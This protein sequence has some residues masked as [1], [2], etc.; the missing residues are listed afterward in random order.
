MNNILGLLCV[1][2]SPGWK[3][4]RN[5]R[6]A[7]RI[8]FL[9]VFSEGVQVS[10]LTS[11]SLQEKKIPPVFRSDK[12]SA[13]PSLT[14][15]R[16]R[17]W[18][19][20]EYPV[21]G[22]CSIVIPSSTQNLELWGKTK[23]L[24]LPSPPPV[25]PSAP[26]LPAAFLHSHFSYPPQLSSIFLL[27]FPFLILFLPLTSSQIA[28]PLSSSSCRLL[29]WLGFASTKPFPRLPFRKV[30]MLTLRGATRAPREEQ[31]RKVPMPQ[32]LIKIH[33]CGV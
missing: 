2:R 29:G 28:S 13:P 10:L 17:K 5:R 27:P 1:S 24:S 33:P 25:S 8:V 15:S 21:T 26:W 4:P 18:D 16:A 31:L 3:Q 20:C 11:V 9:N 22:T 6:D 23:P 32:L 7:N 19:Y 14:K 12:T 30:A